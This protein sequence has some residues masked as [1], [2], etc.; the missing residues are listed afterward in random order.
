VE[1]D[2]KVNSE[3]K[4]EYVSRSIWDV[5]LLGKI[6]S[7]R[8]LEVHAKF[9]ILKKEMGMSLE[10]RKTQIDSLLKKCKSKCFKSV[11]KALKKC[12]NYKLERIPQDFITNIKIEFN[13]TFM[14]KT[15]LQVYQY[16]GLLLDYEE[17]LKNSNIKEEK[18]NYLKQF[19][20]LTFKDA[21]DIYISSNQYLKDYDRIIEKEGRSFAVLFDY[22]ARIFVQYYTLS[23]GNKPKNENKKIKFTPKS[24][25][26]FKI[27]RHEDPEKQSSPGN[28][29][30]TEENENSQ[31]L[32]IQL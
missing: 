25:S 1:N 24:K 18:R 27:M 5:D 16:Y 19:V 21:Y 28:L 2:N 31:N 4:Q 9:Q 32:P 23:K 20:N 3:E 6:Q 10:L 7:K 17:L 30:I 13:K 15:I 11:H 22:I 29:E 12:L 14:E 26:M 8:K